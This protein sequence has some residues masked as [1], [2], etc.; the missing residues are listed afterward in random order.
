MAISIQQFD[1]LLEIET[2]SW[3]VWSDDFNKNGCIESKPE[4]IKDFLRE[5]I[6]DL[7]QNVVLIGLNR[8]SRKRSKVSSDDKLSFPYSNFH[9]KGHA[10]DGL[11]KK[12]VSVLNNI[13]GAYMT[14]LSLDLQSDSS[15]IKIEQTK[16]FEYFVNQLDI[17][18]STYFHIVCFGSKV[19]ETF[20]VLTEDR[21]IIIPNSNGVMNLQLNLSG[22]QLSCYKV[23]HYSY[24]VRYNKKDRF[25]SQLVAISKEIEKYKTE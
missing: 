23:I 25:Q 3:A 24:A 21:S 19:F 7:K 16:A 10:G 6:S 14:D 5:H 20:N 12:V 15:K 22:K 9:T 17:L 8:A 13:S 1:S 11:L 4:N 18:G 2:A